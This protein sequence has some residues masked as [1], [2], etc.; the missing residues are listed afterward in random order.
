MYNNNLNNFNRY[1]GSYQPQMYQQPMSVQDLPIQ[2]VRFMDETQAR[3][4]VLLPNQ[5]EMLIDREKGVAYLKATDNAGNSMCRVFKFEETGET[6]PKE[7]DTSIFL[8]KDE[9]K[10][11]VCKK[12]FDA[13]AEKIEGLR[14]QISKKQ[15]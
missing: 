5:K 15:V 6:K 4:Y 13:L 3:A 1:G 14:S 11:F 2:A 10:D 8:T 12:D 7:V 9:S